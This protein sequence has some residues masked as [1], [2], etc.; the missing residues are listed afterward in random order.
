[1]STILMYEPALA[2]TWENHPENAQRL[3]GMLS[4]LDENGALSGMEQLESEPAGGRQVTRVHTLALLER[5]R[6]AAA[7]G[8]GKLDPDTYVTGQSYELALQA[9]GS[10]C[11][12]VDAI[13]S[14]RARNGL[15]LVRPPGH[16]ATRARVGGFCLFNN[17]A[18]AARQAQAV[19]GARRILIVDYDV[20]HGN[21]TQ[22]IF[23][24]DENVLYFSAHLFHPFFY[25]G[26]GAATEIGR[27]AGR[28]TTVN[29]PF[30]RGVGKRGYRQ[31]FE[32]LLRPCARAF[33][34]ELLLVSVGFDAHW[35]DPLASAAL[36]LGGY[37]TLSRILLE[38]AEELCGGKIL[39]VLEGG[40]LLEAMRYGVLNLAYAL[41]GRDEV[42]DPLGPL[43]GHEQAV[44][45]L[46]ARLEALHML[47]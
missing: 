26:T 38:L 42:V 34:P 31:A 10:C 28:G 3:A 46:I 43:P 24:D 17:V 16:H 6:Q 39:F 37:A 2:H 45:G 1:M 8:G 18:I 23:Y 30:P 13:M 33:R 25:P 20:H 5:V 12:A 47:G 21:G 15:A 4:F 22:D 29:V 19:H 32:K 11:T 35:Q 36:S 9:A 7:A 41:A 44:D 14:G 27:G 40:Y